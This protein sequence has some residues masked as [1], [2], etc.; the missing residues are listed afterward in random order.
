M[1]VRYYIEL[2]D[3]DFG[4]I[5]KTEGFPAG[6]NISD[7]P[8]PDIDETGSFLTV[9]N[10]LFYHV[11][12]LMKQIASVLGFENDQ[13]EFESHAASQRESVLNYLYDENSRLFVDSYGSMQKH[14]GTN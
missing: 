13:S 2:K 5:P 11:L 14:Q 4:L 3:M 6:W 10:C 9:Q 1:I 8:F 12:I 7:W